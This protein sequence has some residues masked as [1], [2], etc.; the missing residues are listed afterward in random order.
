MLIKDIYGNDMNF[1]VILKY[2]TKISDKSEGNY[3]IYYGIILPRGRYAKDNTNQ[4]PEGYF[5]H[6]Q[7]V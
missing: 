5:K 6:N 4:R 1:S 3:P 2:V 7:Y